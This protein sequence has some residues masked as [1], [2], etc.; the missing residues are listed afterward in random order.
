LNWRYLPLVLFLLFPLCT[1]PLYLGVRRLQL[2]FKIAVLRVRFFKSRL[3]NRYLRFRLTRSLVVL[4]R[5]RQ[6]S[7][8]EKL[9]PNLG[10]TRLIGSTKGVDK[11][12]NPALKTFGRHRSGILTRR[13]LHPS[14]KHDR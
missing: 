12:I 3:Q 9:A 4:Q 7:E 13:S 5:L 6:S 10:Q 8:R 11:L 1:K 2:D 14:S